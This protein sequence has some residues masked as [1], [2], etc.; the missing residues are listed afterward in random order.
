MKIPILNS[1]K[2]KIALASVLLVVM[3]VTGVVFY[4]QREMEE[5]NRTEQYRNAQTLLLSVRGSVENQYKSI[6]FHK[7]TMLAARKDEIRSVIDMAYATLQGY[8]ELVKN[9]TLSEDEA[10]KAA[11]DELQK[12]RYKNGVGYI[13]VNDSG[14]PFPTMIMHPTIPAL[15]GTVLDSPEFNCALGKNE[16]LFKAF[17]DIVADSGEGFVD[18]EW[19][20]PTADG[21]TEKQPKIS[22]VKKFIPWDWIIGSGLYIDDLDAHV[23]SRIEAVLGELNETFGRIRI[24]DS[25]YIYIFTGKRKMIYH[26]LYE[27]TIVINQLVNPATGNNI[28]DD[29]MV[30]ANLPEGKIE[31]IWDKPQDKGEFIYR[32]MAFITH[33]KPLDWYIGTSFYLDEVER[34]ARQLRYKTLIFSLLFVGVAVLL[35]LYTAHKITR[36]LQRMIKVFAVGADGDYSARMLA[37][38]GGEFGRLGGYFNRFMSEIE[39]SH[40]QLLLSENR[41]RTLF[42]KSTDA[43]LIMED[44]RF[45]DCNEAAVK[46]IRGES[47][48]DII[49]RKPA[50]FAPEFQSDGQRSAERADSTLAV[51]HDKGSHQFFCDT[52]R[53]D[54]E[55]FP[56]IV[57]LTSILENDKQI[58]HVL[59]RDITNQKETERQLVQSQKM[60][61][62]GTLAGGLAHDFNNVLGGIVGVISLVK[63]Q[64]EQGKLNEAK[65]KKHLVTMEQAGRRASAM[66]QQL[67]ALSRKQE[68]RFVPV[69]LN[70]SIKHV[71]KMAVNSFDKSVHLDFFPWPE[72]AVT[73]GDPGQIEQVLLNCCVNG[74][75][76]MT[77]MRAG[78]ERRGGTLKVFIDRILADKEFREF[79]TRATAE[80]Y[81][82]VSVQDC[83]VGMDTQ[84]IEK[85]FDPFFTTKEKNSGTGLG[86]SMVY[87]IVRD[88]K[89]FISVDSKVNSGTTLK[90][91]FPV[92][93][94]TVSVEEHDYEG[95]L[96]QFSGEGL[97]LVVDDEPVM[98]EMAT[99]ILNE[100]GFQVITA[101][102][103]Q[104]CVA[105]F[106]ERK[107]EIRAVILDMAMPVMSGKEA[108]LGMQK[109]DPN[110]CVI[111]V[112]GFLQDDRVQEILDLGVCGFVQKPYSVSNFME[113]LKGV[114]DS[115]VK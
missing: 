81:W 105:I 80:E 70:Y 28:L 101:A 42:E 74:A 103:G 17:V 108:Y 2:L 98:R 88:L 55:M 49:S 26:P 31:Y 95:H 73:L 44:G 94:S 56:S 15:D 61:T 11:R 84:T 3:T 38:Q 58:V 7:E 85:M 71:F 76:A 13:W 102:D 75:H 52:R 36:P 113:E 54:G 6:L 68:I 100:F 32:K 99:Q 86:L 29:L 67:L 41:F 35:A 60:E 110:V 79:H 43:R 72:D 45:I 12:F 23:N 63:L 59:W 20:K 51:I 93:I 25:G 21:L 77:I 22:F 9:G 14:R 97:I 112:S 69:D 47:K 5:I 18:Y 4:M 30:A 106:K 83:G 115:G 82:C 57:E 24:A 33:F 40:K 27:G 104:E 87:N 109:I 39:H 107:G 66:V 50:D 53:I 64:M 10:K 16:N 91:F 89:G 62:V 111:L 8:N 96:N 37:G 46:M 78:D 34:P 48:K 1:L 19:P 65:L 114:L 92:D 90:L